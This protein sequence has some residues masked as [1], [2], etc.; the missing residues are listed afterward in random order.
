MNV[1]YLSYNGALEPLGPN[2]I[3]IYPIMLT[4]L[5]FTFTLVTFEKANDLRDLKRVQAMRK[6]LGD[7]GITWHPLPYHHK[8]PVISTFIDVLRGYLLVR[9]LSRQQHF[10][11]V[12]IR[13]YVPLLFGL[14][15]HTH[16]SRIIFDLRGFW[17]D[18]RV[19]WGN[20]QPNS[21]QYRLIKRLEHW[22]LSTADVAVVLSE[23]AKEHLKSYPVVQQS[24]LPIETVV[25]YVD[26][27]RFVPNQLVRTAERERHG[28]NDQRILVHAGSLGGLH[29]VEEIA[30][31]FAAGLR[32]DPRLRLLVLSQSDSHVLRKTLDELHIAAEYWKIEAVAPEDMPRALSSGDLGLAL[33]KPTFSKIASWPTKIGE[34]LAMGIPILATRGIGDTE[35]FLSDHGV[36]VLVPELSAAGCAVG[37]A[38]LLNLANH[39]PNLV[40]HCRIIAL[41]Y[42]AVTETGRQRYQAIYQRVQSTYQHIQEPV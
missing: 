9:K 38:Q 13:S 5:G 10:E 42:L 12:H 37:I 7:K 29:L 27:Q 41:R 31:C 17:A 4:E 22:G 30:H 3:V 33:I 1:L 18:E 32:M 21:V 11:I 26:T 16:G 6:R 34:Y 19:D 40:D 39:T 15:L 28:W 8:P 24:Q 2:Q 20:C 23:R 25:C 14:F 35:A 36:G